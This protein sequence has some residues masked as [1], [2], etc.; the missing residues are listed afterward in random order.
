[1]DVKD[2]KLMTLLDLIFPRD[3]VTEKTQYALRRLAL[4]FEN[5]QLLAQ[6]DTNCLLIEDLED[7]IK[8]S[9]EEAFSMIAAQSSLEAFSS[10]YDKLSE[11][12]KN[13][14]WAGDIR[15]EK[16]PEHYLPWRKS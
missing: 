16:I 5:E 7:L 9:Y 2:E 11:I 15:I 4:Y 13:R 8:F 1:M 6:I 14:Y 3:Q 12:G 10:S